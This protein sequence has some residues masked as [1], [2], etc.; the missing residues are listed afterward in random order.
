MFYTAKKETKNLGTD[1]VR[2]LIFRPIGGSVPKI[3]KIL[4]PKFVP[5]IGRSAADEGSS[6]WTLGEYAVS[7]RSD[8]R[9]TASLLPHSN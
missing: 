6:S 1:P 9:S 3:P 7:T 4:S 8:L 5:K 2:P